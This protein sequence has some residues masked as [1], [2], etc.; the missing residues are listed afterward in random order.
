MATAAHGPQHDVAQRKTTNRRS[1][2]QSIPPVRA[3]LFSGSP[4]PHFTSHRQQRWI[5]T[6]ARKKSPAFPPASSLIYSHVQKTLPHPVHPT[7][8]SPFSS[9]TPFIGRSLILPSRSLPSYYYNA[10]KHDFPP[11][12]ALRDTV[13][14]YP[15]S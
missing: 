1:T 4:A 14:F 9:P 8:N 12:G 15:L 2:F 3:N 11:P 6:M 10:S 13:F 5:R 7:L